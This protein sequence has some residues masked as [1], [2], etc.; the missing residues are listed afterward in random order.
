MR[1][2]VRP[3]I[4]ISAEL[5][6]V[7]CGSLARIGERWFGFATVKP[8]SWHVTAVT[9]DGSELVKIRSRPR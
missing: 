7:A 1:P 6:I 9:L 2:A 8:G 3:R 5:A 4:E